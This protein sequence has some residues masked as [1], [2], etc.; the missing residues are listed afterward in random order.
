MS[1]WLQEIRIDELAHNRKDKNA[2]ERFKVL[3]EFRHR[4]W[5]IAAARDVSLFESEL[6]LRMQAVKKHSVDNLRV[7]G[8]RG[9]RWRVSYSDGVSVL[10]YRNFTGVHIPTCV[11]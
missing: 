7:T 1:G 8:S 6:L 11:E 3:K 9:I 5:K 10:L 4:L 2:F